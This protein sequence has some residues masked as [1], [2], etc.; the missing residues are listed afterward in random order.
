VLPFIALQLAA[1]AIVWAYPAI[2]T[3]LPQALY[4]AR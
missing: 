2:A 4:G 1:L 3:W